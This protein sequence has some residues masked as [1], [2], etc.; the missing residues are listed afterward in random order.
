VFSNFICEKFADVR[1]TRCVHYLVVCTT[2][3]EIFISV[4]SSFLRLYSPL[5]YI[6]RNQLTRISINANNIGNDEE[7]L[8]VNFPQVN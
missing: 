6:L 7:I 1:S 4:T 8:L 2:F 3:F 5:M